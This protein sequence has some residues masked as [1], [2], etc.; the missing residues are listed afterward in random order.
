MKAWKTFL[1]LCRAAAVAIGLYGVR[2]IWRG[3][4]TAD[5]PSYLEKVAARAARSFATPEK[6]GLK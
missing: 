1:L 4:S 2:L 5:E 3:F 6:H